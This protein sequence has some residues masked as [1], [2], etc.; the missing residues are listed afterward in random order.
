[1]SKL[2][3]S[4]KVDGKKE[5]LKKIVYV[6]QTGNAINISCVICSPDNRK[7]FGKIIWRLN[8]RYF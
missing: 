7:Y 1:M 3:H 6:I 5:F 4:I 2:F 8:F